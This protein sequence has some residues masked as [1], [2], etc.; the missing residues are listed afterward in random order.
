MNNRVIIVIFAFFICVL[1]S[2]TVSPIYAEDLTPNENIEAYGIDKTYKSP[3][4][5]ISS[6][7]AHTITPDSK[8]ID[9]KILRYSTYNQNTKHYYILISYMERFEKTGGGTLILKKGTYTISN[10]VPIP[11][12]VNLILE[13][14]VTIKKGLKTGT[15]KFKASNSIFQ[16]VPPSKLQKKA[17][18]G[19]YNGVS[20]V[21]IVGRGTSTIDLVNLKDG[22]AIMCGHNRNINIQGITFR[23]MN[24]GHYIEVDATNK[25]TIS[26]CKFIGSKAS[27]NINKEAVNLDTPDLNTRGFDC[28]W[29]K[30][31]KTP[32]HNIRIENNVFRQLDRAIGTHKYSQDKHKGN[33]VVNQGQRYHT[34]I[35]IRNN[36]ISN[37]RSDAIRVLNWKD[38]QIINNVISN[39]PR[40]HMNYRGVL[41]V[42]ENITVKYNIFNNM[43]RPTQFFPAKNTGPG[44]QYSVSYLNLNRQ[45]ENDLRYNLCSNVGES[46]TRISTVF[47]RFEFAKQIP[48]FTK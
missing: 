9:G 29:S 41:A 26:N 19:K 30:Q 3:L 44:S 25:M 10:T 6:N 22:V 7:N 16:L 40:N 2:S 38:S 45:N 43:N 27:K 14:G 12:N 18:Y 21:N 5:K 32:N 20:N 28:I 17:V 15:S 33:Y 11:S 48:M 34:Q 13:N 36:E 39:V 35:V 4:I 37:T 8:P 46:F 1:C 31:D 23:N 47:N 42:G 24:A